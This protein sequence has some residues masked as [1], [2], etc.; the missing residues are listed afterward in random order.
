MA[1]PAAARHFEKVAARYT[2]LRG[3]GV[4]GALRRQEQQAVR[5]LAQVESGTRVL[6]VGCGD[7]EVLSWLA[8]QGARAVGVDLVLPM[9]AHCRAR[10]FSVCVQ[11]MENLGVRAVFDWVFCVGSLEF[12]R[13]PSRAIAA[14]AA[15]LRPGGR[16]LLLFPRR[17]WL[18]MAYFAYHR[19]H[20]VPIWLFSR[21]DVNALLAAAGMEVEDWRDCALSSVCSARPRARP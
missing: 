1:H 20:G 14:F 21:R 16:L 19:A 7:G 12:T 6:D 3:G 2:E 4:T 10:G 5:D 9:A 15:A 18:G 11:D 13:D 17:G 8:A